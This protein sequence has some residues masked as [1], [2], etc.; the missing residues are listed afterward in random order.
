MLSPSPTYGTLPTS[1]VKILRR[2]PSSQPKKSPG[3]NVQAQKTLTEREEQYRLARE[4]IFGKEPSSSPTSAASTTSDVHTG[5][6][7][8]GGGS[9]RASPIGNGGGMGKSSPVEDAFRLVPSQVRRSPAG[10]REGTP[11]GA[12]QRKKEEGKGVLR[13]PK[14]PGEGGGFGR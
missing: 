2:E 13:Q 9:A 8:S 6:G 4:R 14:G 3:P 12:G 7:G 5:R 11:V 10:S 1:Q